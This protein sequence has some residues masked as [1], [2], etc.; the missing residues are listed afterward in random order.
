MWSYYNFET[1]WDAFLMAWKA[2]EVQE[3]LHIDMSMYCLSNPFN[4][5]NNH[6][7]FVT[8]IFKTG[9]PLWK[10]SST[11]F[12]HEDAERKAHK[13]IEQENM[14]QKY[15]RTMEN[16]LGFKFKDNQELEEKFYAVCF[17]DIVFDCFPKANS[18]ESFIMT[19]AEEAL[20]ET[21]YKVAQQIFPHDTILCHEN[22]V[23]I[24]HEKLIFSLQRFFF[25]QPIQQKYYD[26]IFTEYF[27]EY[28]SD[29]SI[30]SFS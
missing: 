17:E 26:S 25:K 16:S 10:Y 19:G 30:D 5:I 2:P 13:R 8:H 28:S 3:Q 11:Y 15:K 4:I 29:S 1:N 23:L 18:M 27:S 9:D 22:C 7:E 6:G 24:A 20:T 12:W 21:F 14:I